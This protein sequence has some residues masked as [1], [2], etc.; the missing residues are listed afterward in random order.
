MPPLKCLL[1]YRA[2]DQWFGSEVEWS[3]SGSGWYRQTVGIP[4]PQSTDEIAAF[5]AS[6]GYRI[7]WQ[8]GAPAETAA[9]TGTSVTTW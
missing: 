5:A 2:G 8:D 6:N 1:V 4:I 7:E 3:R 9:D